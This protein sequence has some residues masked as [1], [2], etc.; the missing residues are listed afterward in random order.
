MVKVSLLPALAALII[1]IT[2][3]FSLPAQLS[4]LILT[5]SEP[6]STLAGIL[7]PTVYEDVSE[8]NDEAFVKPEPR[9]GTIVAV[10]P[11]RRTGNGNA[12]IPMPPLKVGQRVIVGADRGERVVLKGQ[13]VSEATHYLFRTEECAR[14]T[15]RLLRPRALCKAASLAE[16]SLVRR[17]FGFC[18]L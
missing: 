14:A 8:K 7:L 18:D 12:V 11:G 1:S 15:Y 2:V 4:L 17:L 5:S 13:A 6:A 10:G 16:R 3:L 9:A